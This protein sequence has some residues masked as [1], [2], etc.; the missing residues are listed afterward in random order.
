MLGPL[1]VKLVHLTKDTVRKALYATLP[2]HL[3]NRW[4]RQRLPRMINLEAT[5]ACNLACALCPTHIVDR[6][7]KFLKHEHV[8][9][10][11]ENNDAVKTVCFHIEGEPLVHPELFK[12]VRAF[13]DRGV[14]THF[15]TNG[16]LLEK[17]IDDM[18]DSGLTSVSIAIDGADAEDYQR[19]RKYGDFDAV[20]RN[21]KKLLEERKK[22]GATLPRV[23]LQTIMFSYNEDREDEIKALLESFGADEIALKR[24]S[25]FNDYEAWK[26]I[27][28][29][30][31]PAKLARAQK[32]ADDFL[33]TVDYQ[34]QDRKW[35][36]PT[37]EGNTTLYRNHRMC[38]QMEKGTVLCDGRVVACCMDVDGKTTFGN[39]NEES[40]AEIWRGERHKRV[41]EEFQNRT[42]NVCQVCTLRG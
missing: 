7:H 23:Q 36:R 21:T 28:A 12:F 1:F 22:R 6:D 9:K 35:V 24:P 27:S 17:R 5:T 26:S 34:N 16:D 8:E 29:K 14:E 37:D 32:G 40:F 2:P 20:V 3:L 19:Y 25:Y 15:G 41:L 11:L 39:L 18:L 31:E 13:A 30:V 10:I 4:V 38:P 42:L 33:A